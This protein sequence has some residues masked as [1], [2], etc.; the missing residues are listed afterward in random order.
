MNEVR[1]YITNIDWDI[2]GENKDELGLPDM[3]EVPVDMDKDEIADMLSDYYGFCVNS[4][5]IEAV[6]IKK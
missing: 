6:E 5:S 1:I 2:D 4:F 3:V